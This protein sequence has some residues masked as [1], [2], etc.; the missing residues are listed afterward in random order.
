MLCCQ[1]QLAAFAAAV[2]AAAVVVAETK[3]E[4]VGKQ[5]EIKEVR[6]QTLRR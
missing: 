6:N 1:I 3:I 2:A 4:M 5:K